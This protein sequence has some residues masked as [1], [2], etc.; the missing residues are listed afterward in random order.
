M[1]LCTPLC[2]LESKRKLIVVSFKGGKAVRKTMLSVSIRSIVQQATNLPSASSSTNT[3]DSVEGDVPPLSP[4]DEPHGS[5][6]IKTK[7]ARFQKFRIKK[8]IKAYH[9]R[10]AKLA[11]YR[12]SARKQLLTALLSRQELAF[13][14]KCVIPSCEE[15]SCGRCLNSFL[16]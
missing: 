8:K 2:L 14:Q 3:N 1:A 15:D 7:K 10:K 11:A 12:L 5:G 13:D 6:F 9:E 16:L 4:H